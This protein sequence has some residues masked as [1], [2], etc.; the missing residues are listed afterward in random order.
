MVAGLSNVT[1]E[2]RLE[3]PDLYPL[4]FRRLRG[5]LILSHFF[6]VGLVEQF[7]TVA[8]DDGRRGHNRKLFKLRPRT[9]LRQQFFSYRVINYWNSLPSEVVQFEL[10]AD[11]AKVFDRFSNEMLSEHTRNESKCFLSPEAIQARKHKFLDLFQTHQIEL[12]I[13]SVKT[14][15]RR[16]TFRIL[17]IV[18]AYAPGNCSDIGVKDAFHSNL[19]ALFR[20]IHGFDIVVLARD[21]TVQ[22]G[23]L[24]EVESPA[25][26][27]F[28]IASH[29]RE[30]RVTVA[31]VREHRQILQAYPYNWS[32]ANVSR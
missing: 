25:S 7:F 29:L 18:S 1:Y 30:W 28:G 2:S 19:A 20:L 23:C 8:N 12:F 27:S 21:M 15:P 5:D 24:I 9:F 16:E 4:E 22:I 26:G 11:V 13:S 3:I 10:P 32:Q 6:R 17:F 31:A 14:G